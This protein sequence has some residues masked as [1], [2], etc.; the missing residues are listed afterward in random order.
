M[1]FK[2]CCFLWSLIGKQRTI[3]K[4]N[5]RKVLSRDHPLFSERSKFNQHSKEILNE[6]FFFLFLN[7]SI[8]WIPRSANVNVICIY[9]SFYFPEFKSGWHTLIHNSS[10]LNQ[11]SVCAWDTNSKFG[12]LGKSEN[13]IEQ[14]T[15]WLLLLIVG[16]FHSPFAVFFLLLFYQLW[17]QN[18]YQSPKRI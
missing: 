2:Y 16:L 5:I 11:W 9:S 14:S 4:F 8:K 10:E 17:I 18:V 1:Q 3:N 15:W 13:N 7:K 6:D 12:S